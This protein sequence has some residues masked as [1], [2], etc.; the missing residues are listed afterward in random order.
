MKSSLPGLIGTILLG[1]F[2]QTAMAQDVTIRDVAPFINASGGN[3]G[4]AFTIGTHWSENLGFSLRGAVG[5]SLSPTSSIGLVAEAGENVVEGVINFGL[6][7]GNGRTAIVS[8]GKMRQNLEV[9]GGREW[10]EQ[11]QLGL[12]LEQGDY[13]LT[14][15]YSAGEGSAT[16]EGSQTF[17][18]DVNFARSCA[19]LQVGIVGRVSNTEMGQYQPWDGR[20]PGLGRGSGLSGV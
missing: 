12:L 17:G 2:G 7:L 10:V 6:D 20:K 5:F 16:F 19:E 1:I 9:T 13:A 4:E 11:N 8:A 18:A 15:F 3:G 14:A